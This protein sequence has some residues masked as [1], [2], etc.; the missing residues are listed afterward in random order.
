VRLVLSAVSAAR[1]DRVWASL[2]PR[3]STG[4]CLWSAISQW[5]H[6]PTQPTYTRIWASCRT[7]TVQRAIWTGWGCLASRRFRVFGLVLV[8]TEFDSRSSKSVVLGRRSF[9]N[10]IQLLLMFCSF[11]HF[12]RVCRQQ[13]FP[14]FGITF[15]PHRCRNCHA[16]YL[17]TV[18]LKSSLAKVKAFLKLTI[19]SGITFLGPSVTWIVTGSNWKHSWI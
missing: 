17:M 2:W 19:A 14:P 11:S 16:K 7:S 4:W 3:M 6:L 15:L 5:I 18:P 12:F 13:S 8:L 10:W 9:C 1:C